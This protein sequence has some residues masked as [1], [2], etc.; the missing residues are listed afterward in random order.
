[1]IL[2]MINEHSL[3]FIDLY[4]CCSF[5]CWIESNPINLHQLID[6]ILFL[7]FQLNRFHNNL[8][9]TGHVGCTC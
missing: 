3:P 9:K 4:T 7:E 1:M 8:Q 5:F 2:T 6:F